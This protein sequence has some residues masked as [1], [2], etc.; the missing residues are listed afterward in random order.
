MAD[1]PVE[2]ASDPYVRW[3]GHRN[4]STLFWGG[5]TWWRRY[6]GCLAPAS[7]RPQ[8]IELAELQAANLLEQ[9]GAL[10]LRYF[11]RIFT[12]PT[13]FWYVAC[14]R[15]DFSGLSANTRSKIRRAYKNCKVEKVEAAWL[16]QN[17]YECYSSAFARYRGARPESKAVFQHQIMDSVDGPF[18]FWAVFA[19]T[20]LAGYTKCVI[21]DDY[22][23]TVVLKFHPDYLPR[24][25]AYA[26]WDA[27]LRN[28]VVADG[29]LVTNGFRA[30]VHDTNVQD[31]LR[32]FGFQL[33]YCDLKVVYQ[34]TLGACVRALYPLRSMVGIIP[35]S[36][37]GAN[38]RGILVQEKV[39]RSFLSR[40]DG[41]LAPS[42]G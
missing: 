4:S 11:S 37:G 19:G 9:S 34:K 7:L 23:A 22:V 42:V 27:I 40:D 14:E 29:K 20:E 38:V 5:G 10:L 21:G 35:D 36:W 15:Y 6:H 1:T 30:F 28:Y 32:T 17:G 25:S 12:E 33:V 39:R 41:R 2:A 8:P 18:D 16:A 3:L 26:L 24:Y 13:G 31:F